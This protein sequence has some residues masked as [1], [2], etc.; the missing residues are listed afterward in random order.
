MT[1]KAAACAAALALL[2]LAVRAEALDTVVNAAN[3]GLYVG[4]KVTF[5]GT[6][7][8]TRQAAKAFFINYGGSY[9]N[10]RF[11]NVIFKSDQDKFSLDEFAPGQNLCTTGTVK[12]YKGVPEIVLTSPSQI[13]E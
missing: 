7:S 11:T 1:R 10:H 3:V 4:Q 2:A 8:Q 13:V 9:P 5:C 12:E 6:V